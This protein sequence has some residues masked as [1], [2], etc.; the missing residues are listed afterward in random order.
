MVNKIRISTK[1][2]SIHFFKKEP[3]KLCAWTDKFIRQ[4]QQKTWIVRERI[5]KFEDRTIEIIES[6]KQKKKMKNYQM[7]QQ[8]LFWLY[9]KVGPQTD[10]C[11]SMFISALLTTANR[12]KI[13][14]NLLTDKRKTKVWHIC[15]GEYYSPL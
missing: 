3:N 15:T 2:Q 14:Q 6:E 13:P 12:L 11:A 8:L 4:V 5:W 7:I 10:T 1:R 9:L